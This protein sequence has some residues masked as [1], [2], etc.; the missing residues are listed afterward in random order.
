MQNTFDASGYTGVTYKWKFEYIAA[1]SVNNIY[2][3]QNSYSD[4]SA[5]PYYIAGIIR[6]N[7]QSGKWL[8]GNPYR[9]H[10]TDALV[11]K[12]WIDGNIS[13]YGI[14]KYHKIFYEQNR[15]TDDLRGKSKSV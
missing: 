6:F 13:A 11:K 5:Y 4:N 12:G 8:Y 14:R 1:N 10:A 9:N 3:T 7:G 15:R 2:V